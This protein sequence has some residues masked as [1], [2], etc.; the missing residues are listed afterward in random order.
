MPGPR[1]PAAGRRADEPLAACALHGQHELQTARHVTVESHEGAEFRWQREEGELGGSARGGKREVALQEA[2]WGCVGRSRSGAAEPR[3][4]PRRQPHE[5]L[6]DELVQQRDAGGHRC[7]RLPLLGLLACHGTCRLIVVAVT[8]S[9]H[10]RWKVGDLGTFWPAGTSNPSWLT[11]TLVFV[12]SVEMLQFPVQ[13]EHGMETD[14]RRL[15]IFA[16]LTRR[17]DRLMKQLIYQRGVWLCTICTMQTRNMQRIW[18][19]IGEKITVH[20]VIGNITL[21]K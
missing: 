6:R 12:A 8:R 20:M 16:C 15:G 1:R 19:R 4:G 13:S 5:H 3:K 7:S 2:S 21:I 17:L 11:F 14:L 9:H 10:G 18:C